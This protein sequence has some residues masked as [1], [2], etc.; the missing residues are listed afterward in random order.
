MGRVVVANG[1]GTALHHEMQAQS[2][3]DIERARCEVRLLETAI[4]VR[5]GR[6]DISALFIMV[7][8]YGREA[9]MGALT[10]SGNRMLLSMAGP[11]GVTLAHKIALQ[12]AYCPD[13]MDK[14]RMVLSSSILTDPQVL[15][16][17]DRRGKK[18]KN[19]LKHNERRLRQMYDGLLIEPEKLAQGLAQRRALLLAR[20]ERD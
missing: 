8:G 15:E 3:H 13:V 20:L 12:G 14:G 16:Y 1:N 11:D 10:A 6:K 5:E 17:A 19:I 4:A 2:V 7:S 9:Y 18:V